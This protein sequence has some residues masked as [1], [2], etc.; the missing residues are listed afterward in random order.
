MNCTSLTKVTV[1]N[2]NKDVKE[3]QSNFERIKKE[4]EEDS[5][6]EVYHCRELNVLF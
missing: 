2:F 6:T 1:E 4:N 3:E 5:I